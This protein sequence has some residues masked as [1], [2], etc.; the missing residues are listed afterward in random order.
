MEAD[1]AIVFKGIPENEIKLAMDT[2]LNL[3]ADIPYNVMEN[4]PE[5]YKAW[6]TLKKSP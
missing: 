6:I 2:L 1:K 3:Q 5:M 4:L